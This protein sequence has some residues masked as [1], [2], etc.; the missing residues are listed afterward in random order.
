MLYAILTL[1]PS[2]FRGL[3]LLTQDSFPWQFGLCERSLDYIRDRQPYPENGL[4]EFPNKVGHR[5]DA[6]PL[7]SQ[8]QKM[9]ALFSIGSQ[10]STFHSVPED[11]R[12]FFRN[13]VTFLAIFIFGLSFG[14]EDLTHYRSLHKEIFSFAKWV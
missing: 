11:L 7:F 1:S 10:K 8:L 12:S 5:N 14:G 9:P 3:T 4:V 13:D 6:S 2:Y